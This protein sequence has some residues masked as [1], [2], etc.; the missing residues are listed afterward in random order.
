M[1]K[2]N[3]WKLL[4][5]SVIILLPMLFGIVFSNSLPEQMAT[6][7][8]FDGNVDGWS[9]SAFTIYGMPV[10]MLAIHWLC[11]L[12]TWKDPKN[13]NQNNKIFS[14]VLWICPVASL[15]SAGLMYATAVGSEISVE[16]IGFLL[17]G[18]M[19]VAIGN[20]M[21]KCKQNY[22]IGIKV[23]WT[24]E[25]EENWNATHRLAGKIWVTGGILILVAA[26]LPLKIS[27]FIMISS[28]LALAGIPII[29]SY[30]YHKKQ[31]KEGI[32]SCEPVPKTKTQKIITFVSL[33]IVAII[34]VFVGYL[35]FS[36]DINILYNEA[37]FTVE[38][39]YWNDLTVEYSAIENIEYRETDANGARTYGFG[40]AKLSLGKFRNDEFGNYTRYSYVSSDACVVLTVQGKILVI[41]GKDSESTEKIYNELIS[42]IPM[43]K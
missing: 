39:S 12:F 40:S 42:R 23:K 6:H 26:F 8:G 29:Y 43:N 16:I 37:S 35:M 20:Y 18:L 4:I 36:G 11:V 5:S 15:F 17:L 1:L 14:L 21:P 32:A 22:T 34:L 28:M 41:N 19:F 27:H 9:S 13:K 10:F 38:A 25:N 33:G 30:W 2:K 31:L 3:K 7:W 24:L